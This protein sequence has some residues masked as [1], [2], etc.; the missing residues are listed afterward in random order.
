MGAVESDVRLPCSCRQGKAGGVLK[1]TR[2]GLDGC[3]THATTKRR[4]AFWVR[5][6][7]PERF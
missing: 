3:E 6:A 5:P 7:G 2:L 1:V 4:E